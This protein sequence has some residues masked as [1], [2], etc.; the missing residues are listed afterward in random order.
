MPPKYHTTATYMKSEKGEDQRNGGST[1][2]HDKILHN[3]RPH[4]W[5]STRECGEQP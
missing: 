1:I 5:R 4:E 3:M 2:R